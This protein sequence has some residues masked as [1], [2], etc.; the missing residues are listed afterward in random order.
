MY[1]CLYFG[2]FNPIHHGHLIVASHVLHQENVDQIWFV[3]SPHNP[4]KYE[5]GLLNAYHRLY[6]TRLAV[7]G[8]SGF[9]VSDIEFSLPT[10]SYTIDTPEALE[11]KYPEHKFSIL[12]GSDSLRS[13]DKWKR[14][15][16]IFQNRRVFVYPREGHAI[17]MSSLDENWVS[18][19]APTLNISASLVRQ[20]VKGGVSIRYY[21]PE[22]V[23]Q[24]IEKGGYYR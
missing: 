11:K 5:H 4:F 9:R 22:N 8:E 6:L 7:E 17:N 16:E 13:V 19:Q 21:V 12:L 20:L 15:R 3:V 10:P 18:C 1:V 24:E 23:R 2:S 14:S